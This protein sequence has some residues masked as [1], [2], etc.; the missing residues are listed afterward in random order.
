MLLFLARSNIRVPFFPSS[1]A[2]SF[3][4]S[5]PPSNQAER[6]G[7]SE[8]GKSSKPWMKKNMANHAVNSEPQTGIMKFMLFHRLVVINSDLEYY[9]LSQFLPSIL[10][11]LLIRH[12]EIFFPFF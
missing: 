3:Q 12:L 8:T 9:E 4:A 5:A 1:H 11:F 2:S 10:P 7:S 6:Q